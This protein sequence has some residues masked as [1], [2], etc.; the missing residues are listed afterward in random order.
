[1]RTSK[2]F[3]PRKFFAV[4]AFLMI[5]SLIT[6]CSSLIGPS[7]PSLINTQ[8]TLKE[9]FGQPA[10]VQAHQKPAYLVFAA[11]GELKGYSGCNHLFGRYHQFNTTLSFSQVAS[12]LMACPGNTM[13][14]E[15]NL[16]KL[17]EQPITY[18]I[19]GKTL[20]FFDNK[21][22]PLAKFVLVNS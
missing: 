18:I 10:Q 12:T 2:H 3:I 7:S 11:S 5:N 20:V 22:Q 17:L 6:G 8:W 16:M 1:M 15:S 21:Q 19:K 4:L 13:D 14:N 9:I